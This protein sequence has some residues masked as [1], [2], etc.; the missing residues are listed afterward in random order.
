[1][2]VALFSL[3]VV[4]ARRPVLAMVSVATPT[5]I[6]FLLL[7]LLFALSKFFFKVFQTHTRGDVGSIS[8]GW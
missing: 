1:V 2:A 4:M 5:S 6:A 8:V 3:I 7:V